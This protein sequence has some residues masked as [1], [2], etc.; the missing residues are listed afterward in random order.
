MIEQS[1]T[2]MMR[3]GLNLIGQALTIYDQDLRLA[4]SNRRF[5]EMFD[6]PDNLVAPGA[7]FA[8]TIQYLAS[9]GEYGTVDDVDAF[10]ALRTEQ[11]RAFEPHYMERQRASGHWISV[12][13]SPLRQGGWVTVYTDISDIKRQESLLRSEGA[14]LS[15]DLLTRS[16]ELLETN[17]RLAATVAALEETKRDL[18]ESEARARMTAEMTPAH[19]AHVDRDTIYTYSNRK[20]AEVIGTPPRNI[21]GMT[22]EQALGPEAYG[23]IG[24]NFVKAL[25]GQATVTEFDLQENTRRVRVALTPDIDNDGQING[26]YVLS[27]DITAEAQARAALQQTR[28]RELA[29]QLTSGLAHDFANLLTIILGLQGQLERME[30]LP[31]AACEAVATTKAAAL[32][33]GALLEKL[34]NV[35]GRRDLTISAVLIDDLFADL[36]ALA[37][38]A[39]PDGII[40][41]TQ[42]LDIFETVMLDRGY[43]QDGLLNLIL[44]ARDAILGSNNPDGRIQITA[45]LRGATWVEFQVVD[46]GPGFTETA[47][48]RALAPFFTTKP[49]EGSGLGL[50]MVYDFAQLSGGRIRIAN[51]QPT[52][53]E[54]TVQLPLRFGA[55]TAASGIVLL[56]EDREDLRLQARE[57]LRSLGHAVIET[58]SATEALLLAQVPGISHVVS[59]IMLCDGIT[60]LEL[61]RALLDSGLT[62]PIIMMTGLPPSD[63]IRQQAS[64]QFPLLIKPFT[65]PQLA[66]KF[67]EVQ[68]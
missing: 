15:A 46:S 41:T 52:G 39:L 18:T 35:S 6:L 2:Q 55:S 30:N 12:E 8:E 66:A 23:H 50:T 26:A 1:T 57:M 19:I 7:G 42:N 25:L 59:D 24:P 28:K 10:V 61:A 38:A 22:A 27:M 11:A 45:H 13:G 64:A 44:N 65:T 34:A 53:A 17:R 67:N 54:V 14:K 33:G 21:I 56:V 5:Q 60:G 49:A 31:A 51:L 47:L 9:R 37:Q 48:K 40:L 68:A 43:M 20:L 63:P 58:D 3:A 4:V 16:E 32:R 36:V 62:V 29:A